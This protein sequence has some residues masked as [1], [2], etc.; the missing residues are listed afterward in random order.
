MIKSYL[1]PFNMVLFE[2]LNNNNIKVKLYK[3]AFIIIHWS[4]FFKY[5]C[6]YNIINKIALTYGYN[7][8]IN[9]KFL[10]HNMAYLKYPGQ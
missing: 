9:Q 5:F 7:N 1:K 3:K 4:N 8:Y 6:Q 2:I 10:Q